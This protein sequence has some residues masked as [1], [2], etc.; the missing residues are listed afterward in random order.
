MFLG[1]ATLIQPV[2]ASSFHISSS[3]S[4]NDG[5]MKDFVKPY[6]KIKEAIFIGMQIK[7]FLA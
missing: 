5:Q 3:V 4:H 6:A 7:K 2:N 1:K